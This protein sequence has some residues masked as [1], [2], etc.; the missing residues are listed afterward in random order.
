MVGLSL[1]AGG[2]LTSGA[3]TDGVP[4][5][6]IRGYSVVVPDGNFALHPRP[7][8]TGEAFR[9]EDADAEEMATKRSCTTPRWGYTKDGCAAFALASGASVEIELKEVL[10]ADNAKKDETI[11]FR[12]FDVIAQKEVDTFSVKAGV[13]HTFENKT[14]GLLD[15]VVQ[16]CS[17]SRSL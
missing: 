9:F 14:E 8:A 6:E 17:A 2:A 5:G 4:T 3:E 12:L 1:V 16:H 13:K 7:A 11:H 15:L 10:D